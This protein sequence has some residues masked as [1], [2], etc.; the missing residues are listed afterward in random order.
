MGEGAD[1]LGMGL[2]RHQPAAPVGRPSGTGRRRRIARVGLAFALLLA[3]WSATLI[4]AA[5]EA[6]SVVGGLA[7]N[8]DGRSWQLSTAALRALAVEVPDSSFGGSTSQHL[9]DA[10][11]RQF[12]QSVASDVNV[13]PRD[14]SIEDT[15]IRQRLLPARAGR[16]VNVDD[17]VGEL[18]QAYAA[19]Q[20]SVAVPVVTVP[21]QLTTEALLQRLGI[22]T[23]LA[24][25]DSDFA[26]SE[27]S[28]ETNVRL[29]A[30][31]VD[32]TMVPPGENFSYNHA[33]GAIVDTPGFVPADA[34]ESG[35]VGTALG[36]G[37]CQISTTV[38]RAALRAGLPIVE[39][40][41]HSF[42]FPVYEQGGWGPGFDA[43]IAQPE[44]DPLDGGDFKFSNPTDHWMLVRVEI[45]GTHVTVKILGAPTGY[46]VTF[47][48]PT[49][50]D[51]VPATDAAPSV[52]VDAALPAGTVKQIEP[53]TDGL[54]V[55][56][57][58]HVHDA[59]GDDVS[60]DTFV[61]QYQ[62]RG[63]VLQVSPDE[64]NRSTGTASEPGGDD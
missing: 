17:L 55:T 53:A 15:G 13:A 51:S 60:D 12:V 59:A 57:T 32:D 29:A 48:Q 36:G 64:A 38:F 37:V 26:G 4:P 61:S 35:V 9:D 62:P 52:E 1:R 27:P 20:S 31:I 30:A 39:W 6:P 49:V 40:W 16:A 22:T 25:G 45:Q 42:R 3:W 41:P 56:V 28:R 50:E 18:Q 47:D 33:L 58:R 54:T 2:W 19:G 44:E 7:V 14:A 11:L 5:A 34:V 46:V 23:E 43:S 10:A 24:S 21:P 63:P 8:F